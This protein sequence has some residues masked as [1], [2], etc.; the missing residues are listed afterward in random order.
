MTDEAAEQ[1][2]ITDPQ[3]I[4]DVFNGTLTEAYGLLMNVMAKLPINP[5]IKQNS[6]LFFDTGLLWTREA[7]KLI[8]FTETEDK[9]EE[10]QTPT[11]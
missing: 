10:C 5:N 11:K 2:K 9:G 3:E 4:L 1:K 8:K 6:L 7:I